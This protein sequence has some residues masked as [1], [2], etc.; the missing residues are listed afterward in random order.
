MGKM[1]RKPFKPRDP[2]RSKAPGELIVSDLMGPFTIPSMHG[3]RYFVTYTDYYSRFCTVALLKNKS[4]QFANF[5]VFQ[6]RFCNQHQVPIKEF[7]SDKGGEFVSNTASQWFQDNGI[8]HRLTVPGN[9]ESNGLAERMNRTLTDMTLSML[10]LAGLP[11][12]FFGYAE[13]AAAHV[14]NRRPHSSLPNKI[15][16]FEALFGSKPNLDYLRVFGCDAYRHIHPKNRK[17]LDFRAQKL[18]N[19]GYAS[20]AKAY[21]LFDPTTKK[22]FV[23]RD[24][25]FNELTHR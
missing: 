8:K 10:A 7:Q 16:P 17:K 11:E 20:S 1:S 21:L 14:Y 6:A 25:E 15:T 22:E 18:I 13:S 4:D 9:S 12:T 24:V 3:E 23:S 5:R 2:S 19:V